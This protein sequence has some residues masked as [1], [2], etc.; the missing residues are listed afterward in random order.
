MTRLRPELPWIAAT[1]LAVVLVQLW[2]HEAPG[3]PFGSDWGQYLQGADALWRADRAAPY[4]SWRGPLYMFLLG[5]PG[6]ALGYVTAGRLVS[7]VAAA[8]CV[9]AAALAARAL[10]G[11]GAATIAPLLAA[12]FA[13]LQ[14]AAVQVN[15]YAT[16]GALQGLVLAA[17]LA[18]ARWGHRWLALACGLA[19]AAAVA[20]DPRGW[21]MVPIALTLG[22]L[23]PPPRTGRRWTLPA[24]LAG[25]MALGLGLTLWLQR[26]LPHTPLGQAIQEQHV[27][28]AEMVG[29]KTGPDHPLATCLEADSRD[30][31]GGAPMSTSW[32]CAQHLLSWNQGRMAPRGYTP[33]LWVLATLP[34]LLLPAAW[35]RRGALAATAAVG[36]PGAALLAGLAWVEWAPRYSVPYTVPLAL[37][38]P[39]LLLGLAHHAPG[40]RLGPALAALALTAWAALAFPSHR[41]LGDRDPDLPGEGQLLDFAR[42]LDRAAGDGG[43]VLNCSQ[44]PVEVLLLPRPMRA[45]YRTAGHAELCQQ[46]ATQPDRPSG[47]LLFLT[48][49]DPYSGA[50][51]GECAGLDP[52]A[53]GWTRIELPDT[54]PPGVRGWER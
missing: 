40:R 25:A 28:S 1:A 34:L 8:L 30:M 26:D 27:L 51:T 43:L 52:A 36:V 3:F 15:P 5:G 48:V 32:A 12:G 18:C 22:L 33:P 53:L 13:P 37:L 24:L 19:A 35:G 20:T 21:M 14:Q 47:R 31:R 11:R 29:I 46:W 10:V 7:R 9:V 2:A 45:S 49:H 38:G 42:W 17:G 54:A 50:C 23:A 41:G 6:Q 39:A 44:Q 16:L 4:P